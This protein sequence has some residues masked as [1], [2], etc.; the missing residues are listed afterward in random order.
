ML[1]KICALLLLVPL[2]VLAQDTRPL[3]VDV[4]WEMDR[5][6]APVVSPNGDQVVVPVTSYDMETDESQTRLW[7]LS[8]RGGLQRALTQEGNS[9][10]SPV[11][12]PDGEMLAFTSRRNDDEA[13]QVYLLPMD[14]PGEAV[15]LTD[16]PTGVS[17]LKWVGEHIY[18][19]S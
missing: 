10:G 17:S 16:V 14:A 2:S 18:F 13:S 8:T 7:L 5:V 6:G 3:S 11:F 19:I 12:S 1:R 15:R 9:A 4:L